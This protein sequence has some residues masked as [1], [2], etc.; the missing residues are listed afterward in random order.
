M[1]YC[2]F[3]YFPSI[4]D[5]PLHISNTPNISDTLEFVVSKGGQLGLVAV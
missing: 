5:M 1:R 4:S 3:P 2:I